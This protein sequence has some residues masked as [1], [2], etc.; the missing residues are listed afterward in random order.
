MM[1]INGIQ[2]D[3]NALMSKDEL[4]VFLEENGSSDRALAKIRDVQYDKFGNELIWRYPISEG[5]HAGTFIIAVRDGFVSVP[6]DVM[7]KEEGE[8]LELED[9]SMF[10]QESMEIFLDDWLSLSDDLV[11]AMRDILCAVGG[12]LTGLK[13]RSERSVAYYRIFQISTEP[14]PADGYISASDYEDTWFLDRVAESVDEEN[15]R[16]EDIGNLKNLLVSKKAAAFRDTDNSFVFLPGGKEA[17]FT[18]AYEAFEA[19]RSQ[20]MKMGLSEFASGNEFKDAVWNMKNAHCEVFDHYVS[21]GS[22]TIPF[23]KFIRQADLSVRYYIGGV[24]GFRS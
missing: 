16:P 22:D 17:Y 19:A 9:A 1:T 3:P 24:V 21:T 7:E 12:R 10:D 20:T 5:M 13:G 8:I 15:Q 18:K 4:L 11:S 6:Y 14:V 2:Y 23:D